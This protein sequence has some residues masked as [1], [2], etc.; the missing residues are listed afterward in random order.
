MEIALADWLNLTFR[1]LHLITGIAWIGASFYFIALDLGLRKRANLPPGVHGESWNVHGGGFYLMQK[2]NVAPEHMPEEL[3]WFKWEAYFTFLSGFALMSV[4]YYWGAESFLI[5]TEVADITQIQGIALSI[6]FLAGGWILYDVF[7]RI[8]VF[9][10]NNLLLAV[11][12][13]LLIL[14]VAFGATHVFSG[15]AAFVH[16]GAVV[17]TIMVGNVFF[18]IIPNQKKVVA[19]LIAGRDPDPRLGA[20]GKQRSTHNN[21]L[22][23]PVLLMMTS[24]HFPMIFGHEQSWVVVALILIVGGII[25]DFFNRMNAG[26]TGKILWWQ[27]P[28]ATVFMFLLI[29]FVSYRP[30][31]PVDPDAKTPVASDALAITQ[32]RCAACHSRKPTD[33]DFDKAPGG[34]TLETIE[35]L[36]KYSS[37]ILK[38]AVLTKAMPLANRTKMT[39]EERATLGLWIRLGM[40]EDE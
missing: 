7:C 38:Q 25:R 20:E 37:K 40:P 18:I 10:N 12:V 24:S 36:R 14:A 29:A 27:W 30:A 11:A 6:G 5:D 2:Y 19:D 28:V 4:I 23:L 13:F 22:T 9:K 3:H 15:R 21:Y 26:Q 35:D 31:V 16:V 1:W 34:V 32:T 33:K 17:G 39:R 8:P